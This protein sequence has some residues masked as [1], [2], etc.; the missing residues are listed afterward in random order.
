MA[1]S[2][3]S[4]IEV[5]D[6]V[7]F[8]ELGGESVMLSLSSSSY[9]GLDEVGT[10]MWGLLTEH[11]RVEPAFRALLDEFDVEED[12]LRQDLCDLVEKLV[13]SGLLAVSDS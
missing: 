2:L 11:G 13:A 12:K 6:G 9:F 8:R 10:R 5:P 4:R 7:L 3:K 1:V